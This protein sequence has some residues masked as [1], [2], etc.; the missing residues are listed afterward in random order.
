MQRHWNGS[1]FRLADERA[2]DELDLGLTVR[3]DVLEHRRVV[4]RAP[5]RREHVHLPR[6]V[7]ELDPGGGRDCLPLVDEPVDEVAELAGLASCAKWKSCGS[8]VSA[9]VGLT[10]R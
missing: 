4:R 7:V 3:V 2:G 6:V 9:A 1:S 5:L 10:A 8:P